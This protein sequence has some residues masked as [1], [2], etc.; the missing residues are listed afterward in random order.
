MTFSL[1]ALK[2]ELSDKGYFSQLLTKQFSPAEETAWDAVSPPGHLS[3]LVCG[4]W[5]YL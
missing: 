3:A 5:G 4:F 2:F 1:P